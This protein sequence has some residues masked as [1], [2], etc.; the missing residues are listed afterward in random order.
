M[1]RIF[2]I[3]VISGL[4]FSMALP[5]WAMSDTV[6]TMSM[7]HRSAARHH[8]ASPGAGKGDAHHGV[9]HCDPTTGQQSETGAPDSETS[10]GSVAGICPMQ[11][12]TQAQTGNGTLVPAISFLPGLAASVYRAD[13]TPV[14]F[15]SSGFSSHTDRG[16]PAA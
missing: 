10:M 2:A 11:C 9:Q 1:R 12:C 8:G 3:T 14:I 15:T 4:I 16:P 6:G 7:C 13:F 5:A